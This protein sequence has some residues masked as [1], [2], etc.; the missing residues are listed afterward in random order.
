MSKTSQNQWKINVFGP[1]PST[2]SLQKTCKAAVW[3]S[4]CGLEASK[5]ATWMPCWLRVGINKASYNFNSYKHLV[6]GL[7]VGSNL[8]SE[9]LENW[10]LSKKRVKPMFFQGPKCPEM[11]PRGLQELFCAI[12]PLCGGPFWAHL[13]LS[14]ALLGPSWGVQE[15]LLRPILGLEGLRWA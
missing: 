2:K 11:G 10:K 14:W 13:G 9:G 4:C 12:Y 15:G 6:E 3:R 8:R 7:Y 1:S 5:T